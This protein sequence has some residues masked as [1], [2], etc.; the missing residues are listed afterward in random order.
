MEAM[1]TVYEFETFVRGMR[2][3]PNIATVTIERRG[4]LSMNQRAHSVTGRA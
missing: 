2:P 4:T 3:T 1:P